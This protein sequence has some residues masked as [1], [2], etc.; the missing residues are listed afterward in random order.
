MDKFYESDLKHTNPHFYN[1]NMVHIPYCDSSSFAGDA[2]HEYKVRARTIVKITRQIEHYLLLV[3][4]R[5]RSFIS[6]DVQTAMK[7]SAVYFA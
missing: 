2:V 7:L 5:V 4:Y 3:P 1:W 6:K